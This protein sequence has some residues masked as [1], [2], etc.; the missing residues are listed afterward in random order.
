MKRKVLVVCQTDKVFFEIISSIDLDVVY[1]PDIS[2]EEF[3]TEVVTYY[4][5]VLRSKLIISEKIIDSAPNLSFIARMGVGVD[6]ICVEYAESKGVRCLVSPEASRDTLAE[7]TIGMILSLLNKLNYASNQVKKGE[8]DRKGSIGHEL[9]GKTV[10][11]IGYGNMGSAVALRLKGFGVKVI[12]YD[13]Y[14]DSYSDG[15]VIEASMNDVYEEADILSLHIPLTSETKYMVDIDYL[16]RFKKNI[17]LINTARGPII[18]TDDLLGL[19]MTGKLV[20]V[21]LDVLDEELPGF[22]GVNFSE[23]LN[24]IA[25]CSNVMLTPHIAGSS[26]EVWYKHASVIANKIILHVTNY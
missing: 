17:Y 14:K 4:G 11:L 10:A 15:N 22:V 19:I 21:A 25:K 24:G 23:S 3:E 1:R 2:Q 16:N 26:E 13:K 9:L 7:H 20:G 5:V 18:K 8:W 6:H 12:S